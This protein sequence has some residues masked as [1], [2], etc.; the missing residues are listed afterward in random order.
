MG[1]D[2]WVEGWVA[3]ELMAVLVENITVFATC[4]CINWGVV[5]R[6]VQ[7]RHEK[8]EGW[9]RIRAEAAGQAVLA[10]VHQYSHEQPL[11][12]LC[13][14]TC[15]AFARRHIVLHVFIRIDVSCRHQSAGIWRGDL[16]Q[17]HAWR[18]RAGCSVALRAAVCGSTLNAI[19]TGLHSPS[20]PVT[21]QSQ[22][23][24]RSVEFHMH[25]W[26]I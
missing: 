21:S 16:D 18:G 17:K 12:C 24:C 1:Q 26:A 3:I 23:G 10:A 8:K 4:G 7:M 13:I 15:Q 20:D 22:K 9:S 11:D 19:R 14:T 2:G 5:E 6:R 25:S